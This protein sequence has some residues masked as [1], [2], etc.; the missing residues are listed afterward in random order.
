MHTQKVIN[1][2]LR[3]GWSG[4]FP[5]KDS[6]VAHLCNYCVAHN[7]PFTLKYYQGKYYID[8]IMEG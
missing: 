8:K 5:Y 7:V 3:L 1:D 6:V 2:F 4:P